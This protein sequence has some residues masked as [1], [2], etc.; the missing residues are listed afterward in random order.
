M[1]MCTSREYY[2]R[3]PWNSNT[4]AVYHDHACTQEEA[5]E[6]GAM[7]EETLE[8]GELQEEDATVEGKWYCKGKLMKYLFKSCRKSKK[9]KLSANSKICSIFAVDPGRKSYAPD[10]SCD[11][12]SCL[13]CDAI[14]AA[15]REGGLM[16]R[17]ETGYFRTRKWNI[18]N[19]LKKVPCSKS[20]KNNTFCC[21]SEY[22]DLL[23]RFWCHKADQAW[24][25]CL[26]Q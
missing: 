26:E 18:V 21:C 24:H 17:C 14:C 8:T 4:Y 6:E 2:Y 11:G 7:Q 15:S 25:V 16:W 9:P 5:L 22:N 19:Y 20:T 10:A 3:M 23:L 12:G 1:Y 13:S